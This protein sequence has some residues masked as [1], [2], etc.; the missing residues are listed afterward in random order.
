MN[1][2][3]IADIGARE[4][5]TALFVLRSEIPLARGLAVMLHGR[6]GAP[7]QPQIIEAAA[8]LSRHGL[9]VLLP[10]LPNSAANSEAGTAG[11]AADRFTM[12]AHL[13]DAAAVLD[14]VQK[15]G[16]GSIGAPSEPLLLAGHS[17]GAYAALR[18]AAE[19]REAAS[20]AVLAISAVVSGAALLTAR[21]AM[22]QPALDALE[23]EVPGATAEYAEHDLTPLAPRLTHPTAFVTGT[24][25]GLTR[26][27][28]VA[29]FAARL[30]PAPFVETVPEAEH[31]PSGPTYAEALDR[32][33]AYLIARW[34]ALTPSNGA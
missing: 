4:R 8:V 28:D 16:V 14:W 30:S 13:A 25:D 3:A 33:L 5:R 34:P 19:R 7:D 21:A 20:S 15:G 23:R 2:E 31:C 17:M 18:L 12:T 9:N 32:A 11:G 1:L 22:G 24:R 10:A 29:A 27:G 26:P 6:N